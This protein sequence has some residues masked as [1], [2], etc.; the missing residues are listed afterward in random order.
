MQPSSCNTRWLKC[1]FRTLPSNWRQPKRTR[2][3]KLQKT[4][5]SKSFSQT[6]SHQGRLLGYLKTCVLML[7]PPL[8]R[9]PALRR[10]WWCFIL[11]PGLR[12]YPSWLLSLNMCQPLFIACQRNVTGAKGLV[13]RRAPNVRGW[14][15]CHATS[16]LGWGICC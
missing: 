3:Q 9:F 13:K 5:Q 8:G 15:T 4:S 12:S 10:S 11:R 1:M 16:V 2:T 7:M 6:D 14:A